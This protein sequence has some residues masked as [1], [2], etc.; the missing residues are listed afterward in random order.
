MKE[1][2]LQRNLSKDKKRKVG[3]R[4]LLEIF[5]KKEFNKILK[6]YFWKFFCNVSF[7]ELLDA[8]SGFY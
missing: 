2:I 6:K 3:K 7:S 5:P 4:I 1:I 8:R